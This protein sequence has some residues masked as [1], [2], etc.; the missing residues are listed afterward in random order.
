MCISK[1]EASISPEFSGVSAGYGVLVISGVFGS[2][3]VLSENCEFSSSNFSCNFCLKKASLSVG[4][5]SRR[6]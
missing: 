3:E 4:D 1:N 2:G 6:P 5:A